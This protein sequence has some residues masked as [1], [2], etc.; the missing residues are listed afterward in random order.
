[1]L[2]GEIRK[3]IFCPGPERRWIPMIFL[4]YVWIADAAIRALLH[5]N[6]PG[7]FVIPQDRGY[8]QER[9]QL[10]F[11]YQDVVFGIDEQVVLIGALG[12]QLLVRERHRPRDRGW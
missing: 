7:N 5:A 10:S 11:G 12:E 3:S 6:K 9:S 1:M 4:V 8:F 2:V